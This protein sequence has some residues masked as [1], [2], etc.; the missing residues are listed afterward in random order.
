[1]KFQKI[2]Y[3]ILCYNFSMF[4]SVIISSYNYEK[5][6]KEAIES[7]INQTFRNWEL[8]IVDDGSSDH[9][10]DIIK[11]YC[12]AYPQIKLYT[13]EGNANKGLV[14]TLELG[15]SLAKG[16]WVAFLESDDI[17]SLDCLE[18]RVDAITKNESFGLIFNDV[19][20]LGNSEKMEIL[21][22]KTLK[23]VLKTEYPSCL[24]NKFVLS[25]L[26]LTFSSVM[27]K[28][29][30]LKD[31]VWECSVD[32]LFDW[33]L[34]VQLSYKNK[35][36][37]LNDRLTKWRIHPDSYINKKE[38]SFAIPV[39]LKSYF[40]VYKQN[41]SLKLLFVVLLFCLKYLFAFRT[42]KYIRYR[43]AIAIKKFL[44]LKINSAG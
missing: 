27:I 39:Q 25:N 24:F 6:I 35:F 33:W 34:Y 19:Q 14:K 10:L 28:M 44:G 42:L 3:Q 7:V 8:I 38:K 21:R 1:M 30:I 32:K 2:Q 31:F 22:E 41:K 43:V 26:I 18:K 15:F 9:S 11:E 36:Y 13:H 20:I 37:F 4:I 40:E 17:W 23:K 5:Y 16:D 12:Q 29:E